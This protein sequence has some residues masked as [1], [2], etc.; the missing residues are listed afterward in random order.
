M[1][2]YGNAVALAR[3]IPGA[4]L[5]ALG[6]GWDRGCPLGLSGTLSC[7]P[8]CSTWRLRPEQT[9]TTAPGCHPELGRPFIHS[10]SQKRRSKKFVSKRPLVVRDSLPDIVFSASR[11]VR[12]KPCPS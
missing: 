9:T 4:R 7:P 6:G 12:R 2:P 11:L 10:T 1:S 3:E 8:Y 5:L